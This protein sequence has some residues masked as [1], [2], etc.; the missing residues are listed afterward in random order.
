[1]LLG[2]VFLLLP[3]TAGAT[4]LRGLSLDNLCSRSGVIV[5]GEVV[6][7]AAAWKGGRIYTRVSLRVIH[8]LRGSLQGSLRTGRTISFWHLGGRVGRHAQIV[9]GAPTFRQGERV[10]VFLNRRGGR[11]FVTGMAQGRFSIR[12]APTSRSATVTRQATVT[13][14][15]AGARLVGPK[16]A[17]RRPTTLVRFEKRIRA[18]LR[19]LKGR[20]P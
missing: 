20:A 10:L 3:D 19:T 15:L 12:S 9:R 2:S 7:R 16:R 8:S 13:Q 17:L 6:A 4:L 5:R 18:V 11:L 1:M 14:A